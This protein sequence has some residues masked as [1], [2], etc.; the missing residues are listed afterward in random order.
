MVTTYEQILFDLD[1]ITYLYML[2]GINYKEAVEKAKK[3]FLE[4]EA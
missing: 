3:D 2:E 4:E 1:A